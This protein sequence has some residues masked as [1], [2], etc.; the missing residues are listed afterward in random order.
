M[1]LQIPTVMQ[2][3]INIPPMPNDT[4]SLVF[5][6]MRLCTYPKNK[7]CDLPQAVAARFE[8]VLATSAQQFKGYFFQAHEGAFKEVSLGQ[9]HDS[10]RDVCSL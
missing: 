1:L 5:V 9:W 6:C 8:D 7:K 3:N 2:Y 4:N 10:G